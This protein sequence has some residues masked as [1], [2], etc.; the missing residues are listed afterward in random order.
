MASRRAFQLFVLWRRLAPTARLLIACRAARSLGQ[1]VLVVDFALYLNAL[2]WTAVEISAVYTGGLLL[3]SLLTL[4]SGSASDRF[5]RKPFLFWYGVS[6]ALAALVALATTEPLL[7][8][9]AAIVGA[10]GRGANGAAGPFGPVE[11]AWLSERLAHEDFGPVY[12]LNT[13]VG[14]GGMAAGALLAALPALWAPWLPG[15]VRYRPLFVFVLIGAAVTLWLLPRMAEA[16]DT[17]VD[18]GGVDHGGVDRERIGGAQDDNET[19]GDWRHQRG[20]LVRLMGINALNGLASGVIGPFMAYWFH[21]R[22]GVGAAA[23]APVI[24]AGFVLASVASLWTG[25]L[26]RRLGT[27]WAVVVT[28]LA[29]VVLLAALPFAPTYALAAGCYAL[30]AAFNRGSA[31]ARQAVGVKL[32]GPAHRGLAASLN[33]ISMQVPRAVG[34]VVGGVLLETNLL[35]LPMLIAAAL[36][37][38]YLT[39]YGITFRELD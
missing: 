24:A 20:M 29:G 14:Y 9:A 27:A 23:I 39:L 11:Q 8:G 37:A 21:L 36:Q 32:V 38:A 2:H 10:F 16:R 4:L 31:G 15:D 12:S 6:Q 7:L 17:I 22:Y 26:T 18:R 5:G 25:W 35:A 3:G 34:P 33:A 13:A 30:R 28:R 1:G 19:I